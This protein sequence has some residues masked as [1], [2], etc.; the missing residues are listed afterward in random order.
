MRKNIVYTWSVIL[1]GLCVLLVSMDKTISE[2]GYVGI[3]E[4]R[5]YFTGMLT[6]AMLILLFSIIVKEE[7]K[8]EK[9]EKE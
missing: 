6:S 8:R 7:K 4:M 3:V 2:M 1:F 5:Y 9:N